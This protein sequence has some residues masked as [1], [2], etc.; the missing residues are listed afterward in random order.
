M[1]Q[2]R[3]NILPFILFICLFSKNDFEWILFT[4]KNGVKY[5]WELMKKENLDARIFGGKKIAVVGSG[6]AK[7]IK[8]FGLNPDYSSEEF[9]SDS[10]RNEFIKSHNFLNKKLLRIL[11]DSPLEESVGLGMHAYHNYSRDHYGLISLRESLGNSLNIPA[12]KAIQ[13]VGP[14]DFLKFLREL[15]VK[16]LSAHPN[17]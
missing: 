2:S 6:L 7:T 15:G 16:S 3:L 13:Y 4:S 11:D 10:F 9:N 14:G 8:S 5:F 1:V 12:V 17:V